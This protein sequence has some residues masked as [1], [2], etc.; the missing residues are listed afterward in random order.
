V[1]SIT[2]ILCPVDPSEF[3]RDALR[4]AL[5]LAEWYEAQVTVCH[6]YSA[7]QAAS[8][9]SAHRPTDNSQQCQWR[10][11]CLRNKQESH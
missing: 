3:S 10:R 7:P 11:S 8:S 6:I 1:V 4:H 5:A 9:V 2:R